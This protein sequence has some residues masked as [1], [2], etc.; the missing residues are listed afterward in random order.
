VDKYFKGGE[1]MNST[2]T[3]M[4]DDV[5]ENI[6]TFAKGTMLTHISLAEML[7]SEW[8]SAT[9]NSRVQQ[10]KQTLKCKCGLF[11]E[12]KAKL[13]YVI[14]ATGKEIDHVDGRFIKTVHRLQNTVRDMNYIRLDGMPEEN[15][16][17]TIRIAQD[18]ANTIGLLKLGTQKTLE[19]S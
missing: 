5:A 8:R 6:S 15:K 4:I 13:G 10:L 1:C 17:R 18:R 7:G 14:V 3:K 19:L 12:N 11:L 2:V 16:Q 9:Y